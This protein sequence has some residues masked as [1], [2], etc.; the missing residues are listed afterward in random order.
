LGLAH[1]RL[2]DLLGEPSMEARDI[3]MVAALAPPEIE[4]ATTAVR[5]VSRRSQRS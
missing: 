3:Y 5:R 1:D 2:F 4:F